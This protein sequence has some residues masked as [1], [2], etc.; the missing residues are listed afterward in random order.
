[1]EMRCSVRSGV[2]SSGELGPRL[3][4]ER[5]IEGFG[6]CIDVLNAGPQQ[7]ASVHAPFARLFERRGHAFAPVRISS[8]DGRA[9]NS[10]PKPSR[11]FSFIRSSLLLV[12]PLTRYVRLS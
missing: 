1:M 2:P 7:E 4:A 5:D 9:K 8:G 11:G 6:A 10:L 3:A 12:Q